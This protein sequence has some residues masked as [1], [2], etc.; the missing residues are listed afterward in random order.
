MRAVAD[1]IVPDTTM[2]TDLL[3]QRIRYDYDRPVTDVRQRL[4]VV[5]R[6]A[7]GAQR[8]RSWFLQVEGATPSDTRVVS[9]RF[10]NHVLEIDVPE[11]EHHVVFV[12]DSVVDHVD[13]GEPHREPSWGGHRFP[14]RLT[15][16]DP[17]LVDLAGPPGQATAAELCRR[18]HAALRYEWGTT[19]VRTT[20]AEA[21]AGGV[22]VCQDY[23][24]IM[25]AAC[26]LVGLPARYVSGHLRGEG[27]SHA[28]VEVL[29]PDRD[30]TTCRVEAWDPTHDRRADEGYLTVAVG[31]DYDDV[32]PMSG[33]YEGADIASALSVT[34]RVAREG[35]AA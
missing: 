11:V 15:T 31:R 3:H 7:H 14:T 16:P 29:H 26:H 22:G 24:H 25:I 34:K 32:P 23:A 13:D 20:A 6:A 1:L 19:S 35:T 5:P 2:A 27:G 28:W 4:V 33:S 8:R 17:A 12:V 18:V 10:G 30:G 9:D 21:L